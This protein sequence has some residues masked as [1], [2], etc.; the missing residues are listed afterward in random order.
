MASK[1][2]IVVEYLWKKLSEEQRTV[3]TFDDVGSAIRHCNEE[4]GNDLKADNP[5]NFMKDLL[6][7]GN[8]SKN[9][10]Q[11]LTEIGITGRQL[12]GG[13]RIFEFVKFSEGQVEPFPNP[14]ELNGEERELIIQSLSIP[15]TTKSLGRLDESWLIQVAVNLRV[16]ETHFANLSKRKVLELNHLQTGIKLNRT[17]IDSLF[18]A[19]IEGEGGELLNALVTCEAKQQKDPILGDQIVRQVVSAY[20]S[21]KALDLN[22]GMIIPIA[23]KA[24]KGREAIY[25]VEFECWLPDEA[26]VVEESLKDLVVDCSGI[27]RL[28]PPVP[29]IG[30]NASRSKKRGVTKPE[31]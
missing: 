23:L 20:Q 4:F 12:T 31:I 18:L 7:G 3:A 19:V 5:A 22:V 1:K 6:R 24:V 10:P 28:V 2:T 29:G 30:F 26:E 11:C 21:V 16:L 14:F 9:W 17:E 13:N 8:A 27:Y 25:V 15:L